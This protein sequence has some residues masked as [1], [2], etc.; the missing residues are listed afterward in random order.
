MKKFVF[1]NELEFTEK[2]KKIIEYF[3]AYL[4]GPDI[5][6]DAIK[7]VVSD[8]PMSSRFLKYFDECDNHED[9]CSSLAKIKS[10]IR[11]DSKI[12]RFEQ[13]HEF[14]ESFAPDK[15][16]YVLL[17]TSNYEKIV[18]CHR[19][20]FKS[21]TLADTFLF[22]KDKNTGSNTYYLS[23]YHSFIED[24]LNF[25]VRKN[26]LEYLQKKLTENKLI[27]KEVSL[28]QRNNHWIDLSIKIAVPIDE[29]DS[30]VCDEVFA[31]IKDIEKRKFW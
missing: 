13:A 27:E 21:T 16:N 23:T 26:I 14:V 3:D 10:L 1:K 22:D 7:K 12:Q 29:L 31:V 18:F 28:A 2:G 17:A 30:D 25:Y 4:Q 9:F 5:V 19:K 11:Q 8:M 15:C 20:G 24:F 6:K